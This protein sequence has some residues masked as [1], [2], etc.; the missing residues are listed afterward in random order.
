MA[1]SVTLLPGLPASGPL[2]TAFPAE[3]GRYGREG[4]VVEFKADDFA[5]V[6][7]F[8]PGLGGI[9]LAQIH[10]NK[11]DAVVV[12][13]GDL[14]V[15]D[16]IKRSATFALPAIDAAIEVRDPEGWLFSRQGLA[17]ARFGPGGLCWHTRRLT[18]DGL[19]QLSLFD[20][21]LTGLAWD[22]MVNQWFPFQVDIR[23]GRS[24]GGSFYASGT[25]TEDWER[26]ADDTWG[27]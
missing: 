9:E 2:A 22:P 11:R 15:I 18:W 21:E 19:D 5:W 17:I 27:K 24:S 26:L 3:W 1:L 16:P 12:A 8:K 23:T 25:L 14:W 6:G 13:A 10:P 4:T 20:D 7:N